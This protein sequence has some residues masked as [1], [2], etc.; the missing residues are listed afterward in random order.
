M[1]RIEMPFD[2][3]GFF[4]TSPSV[5]L[6][7]SADG[8]TFACQNSLAS[9]WIQIA[10]WKQGEVTKSDVSGGAFPTVSPDGDEVYT[11]FGPLSRE[12]RQ[13]R[14][15]GAHAI[16][17][18]HG[19]YYLALQPLTA[20]KVPANKNRSLS[21][22][23]AGDHRAF[24]QVTDL[25]GLSAA[26]EPAKSLPLDKGIHLIPDAKLLITIP[27]GESRLVLHRLDVE[28]ALAKADLTYLVVTS[29][30][31][32]ATYKGGEYAYKPTVKS[33]KGGVRW[34]L[35]S[36]PEGM[37]VGPDGNLSWRV[38]AD[39]AGTSAQAVVEVSDASGR[40]VLHSISIDVFDG[41]A[42]MRNQDN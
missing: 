32:S 15:D 25:D 19:P 14:S 22:N 37:T 1:K 24:L 34:R 2:P 11:S 30:P 29:R 36:G 27:A 17:A 7:A 42:A 26:P 20:G 10:V 23:L 3:H 13:Q 9:G 40:Q 28:E 35:K 12:E 21:V 41:E 6:R 18:L 31:P 33:K 5:S 38:P 39:F 8:R 4:Q 16:P